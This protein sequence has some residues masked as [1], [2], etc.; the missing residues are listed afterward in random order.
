MIPTGNVLRP[1]LLV[2][3][4]L[5]F[6]SVLV[7]MG[8]GEY[9]PVKIT[10]VL[11][12][13]GLTWLIIVVYLV[14]GFLLLDLL[15]ATKLLPIDQ[16]MHS[17]WIGLAVFSVTIASI[18]I[19]GNVNYHKK[20]RVELPI[21]IEKYRGEK[22][23]KIVF[24]S[25]LHLGYTISKGEF[26]KWVELIN[27]ENPD[28]VLIGGDIVDNSIRPLIKGGFA[29][30][31]KKI[32]SKHGVYTCLGNHEYISN[33]A[34][35]MDFL[36]KAGVT[37]LKDSSALIDDLFYVVGRDDFHGSNRKSLE[38]LIAPLDKTKPII[39]LDHQPIKLQ[40]AMKNDIDL[41]LSG[42]TH[43]G[44]IWPVNWLTDMIFDISHGY[45]K[46]DDTHYFVSMGI[47]C[48]GGKFRIGS[49]S[50][51]AVIEISAEKQEE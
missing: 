21:T 7:S 20:L 40:E 33:R 17:S 25:D 6:V 31:F 4:S 49:R 30:S 26:E 42:H 46:C 24:I 50:D 5:A 38:Q 48:W 51:Y 39:V 29:E 45:T 28:I 18:M 34:K 19:F 43:R 27:Q 15:R 11:H 13:F 36:A 9:L 37:V 16:F 47:G 22:P 14:F 1:L 23:L 41:Q 2:F 3:I 32:K 12:R 35:S 8:I 10:S 44:Q